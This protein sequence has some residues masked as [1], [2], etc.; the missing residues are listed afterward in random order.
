MA[1]ISVTHRRELLFAAAVRV[2]ARDGLAALSTR[3]IVAEA[4][5]SLASF[6]Y[7]YGSREE[8]LGDIV[9]S[10]V[11]GE[12]EA[13]LAGVLG[14]ASSPAD[15][16]RRA[17]A[18]YLDLVRVDPGR[19]QGMFE[20]T[21]HALRTPALARLATEQYQRYHE[22]AAELLDHV[23][24]RFDRRWDSPTA[25]LARLV[26]A[27]TDGLTLAWLADRDDAAAERLAARAADAVLTHLEEP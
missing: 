4:G 15:A 16:V 8:L 7:A 12:R 9:A 27:L 2:L 5:M 19:E 25:D 10:V 21:Q 20:L 17:F 14:D 26:V 22:V 18:A 3:A 24:E 13:G 1:R 23:A 11:R 6:H